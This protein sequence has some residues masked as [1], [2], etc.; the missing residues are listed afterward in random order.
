MRMQSFLSK[1]VVAL[2]LS[3]AVFASVGDQQVWGQGNCFIVG[4]QHPFDV[5]TA[6]FCNFY[7]CQYMPQ[8][9]PCQHPLWQCR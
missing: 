6:P 9:I 7:G 2:L 1:V 4:Y 8:Q 5:I 3:V